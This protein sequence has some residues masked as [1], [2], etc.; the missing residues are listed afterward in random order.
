MHPRGAEEDGCLI[1]SDHLGGEWRAAVK[2][3]CGF[4]RSRPA[5][6]LLEVIDLPNN[7]ISFRPPTRPESPAGAA[8]ETVWFTGRFPLLHFSGISNSVRAQLWPWQK[9]FPKPG[10]SGQK[11]GGTHLRSR[12]KSKRDFVCRKVSRFCTLEDMAVAEKLWEKGLL[13]HRTITVAC[14]YLP[15]RVVRQQFR[16]LTSGNGG[17][18]PVTR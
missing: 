16:E 4:R 15:E 17:Y 3:N 1:H 13:V 11:S 7:V 18:N 9:K 12:V 6:F 2:R 5:R 10:N 8:T 14:C